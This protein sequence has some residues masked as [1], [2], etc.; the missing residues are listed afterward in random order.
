MKENYQRITEDTGVMT[1]E[2]E[3]N[4]ELSKVWE[5]IATTKGFA[6]WFPELSIG[7][8]GVDGLILFD[9]GNGEYEEMT[10]TAYE[11]N[12][13][14]NTPGIRT[15]FGSSFYNKEQGRYCDS[16]KISWS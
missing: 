12:L 9:F 7:E 6:Q 4:S 11:P 5:L 2:L 16:Q 10:I 14:C 8:S 3:L 15:W 1:F 13:S